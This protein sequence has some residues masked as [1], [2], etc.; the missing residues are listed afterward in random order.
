MKKLEKN[1]AF[2]DS[3]NVNLSVR[4]QW[5]KLDWK[6]LA[7]HLK[8]KY[9]VENIYLFIW[10]ISS[11]QSM[12][13]YLQ[14]LGFICVFKP[15]LELKDGRVK[16]NVDAEL[17]LEVMI[18]LNNFDKAIIITWDWD[19]ACLVRY[20][21]DNNKLKLLI[22]PNEKKYSCFLRKEARWYIDSLTNKRNKLERK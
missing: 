6:K 20:L 7:K 8:K 15:V 14:K 1:F 21:R 4:E 3:Q 22:V 18:E 12:Y 10:Y 5:W 11:N 13:T 16:W 17:V 2:I 9:N 19:F